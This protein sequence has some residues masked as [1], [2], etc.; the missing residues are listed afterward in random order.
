[1]STTLL[2]P[3]VA[4][5]VR[6]TRRTVAPYL[7]LLPVVLVLT[8]GLV[9][10][11]VSLFDQSL[12]P[13]GFGPAGHR[14]L[15][16]YA[17]VLETPYYRQALITTLSLAAPVALLTVVLSYPVAYF[18][19]FRAQ[20]FRTLLLF[21]M[22]ITTFISFL[23]RVFAFRIILG[24]TGL[25][26]Q[27]LERLGVI[28]HPLLFLI[29]SQWAVGVTWLSVFPPITILILTAAM[30][31]VRPELLE[32]ARDLG[33]G[34][35]RAFTKV[36]L[37]LTMP[38]ATAAFVIVLIFS[39]SDF[40]TPDQLGGNIQFA[41]AYISDEFTSFGGDRTTASALAFILMATFLV[42]YLLV[43]QLRKFKGI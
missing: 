35:F 43:N 29:F 12:T 24:D 18:L 33:A 10:P 39:A 31:G 5:P 38:G 30:M 21:A 16:A 20:R 1:L 22:L 4:L 2:S 15:H 27:A 8:V 26:N 7:L 42:I 34:T 32:S 19:A 37:P 40:V 3:P 11:V 23:I 25:F 28:D 14:S 9:F 36:L 13:S 41:G 6:Q 17:K